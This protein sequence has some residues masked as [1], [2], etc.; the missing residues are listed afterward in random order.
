MTQIVYVPGLGDSY[1]WFRS[2]CLR[3]WRLFGV[4]LVLFDANWSSDESLS[5]KQQRFRRELA[6]HDQPVVIGESAGAT[7]CLQ[8]LS[9]H[10]TTMRGVVTLCGVSRSN[11]PIGT[12]YQ[13]NVPVFVASTRQVPS[14][15][16]LDDDRIRAVRAWRDSAVP[17]P[18]SAVAG[19]EILTLWSLGHLPTIA[20]GLTLF[21]PLVI[22]QARS[23][24]SARKS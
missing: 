20:L 23:F 3:L 7:L 12:Y 14:A 17:R 11:L 19:T 24:E 18:Y 5:D 9:A 21:A 10:P 13:R 8:Q 16:R 15:D 1:Q 4:Q 6:R 22:R 2:G